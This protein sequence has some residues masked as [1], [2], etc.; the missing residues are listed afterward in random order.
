[1]F[2]QKRPENGPKTIK[3]NRNTGKRHHCSKFLT[4][5]CGLQTHILQP[6]G[7][8]TT[9]ELGACVHRAV[10]EL[11]QQLARPR[12]DK[13][14]THHVKVLTERPRQRPSTLLDQQRA[15]CDGSNGGPGQSEMHENSGKIL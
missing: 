10:Y 5:I 2:G 4:H 1:M 11:S 14:T 9:P 15:S 13:L 3:K 12:C 8:A 7:A 6:R